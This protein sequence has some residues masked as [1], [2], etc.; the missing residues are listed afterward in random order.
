M[1]DSLGVIVS[2]VLGASAPHDDDDHDQHH[3][4]HHDNHDNY[5]ASGGSRRESQRGTGAAQRIVKAGDVD[6]AVRIDVE[7]HVLHGQDGSVGGVGDP[8]G[9]V[10]DE[11]C[12]LHIANS[13][14][15]SSECDLLDSETVTKMQSCQG[16]SARKLKTLVVN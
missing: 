4:H 15:P 5:D 6:D 8:I 11:C 13:V 9:D 16:S 3:H 7:I 12:T 10:A 14:Q 2:V 1:Q